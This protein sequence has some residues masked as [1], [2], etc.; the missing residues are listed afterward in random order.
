MS[1]L[2]GQTVGNYRILSMLGEG[3]MGVVYRALDTRLDREVA[4]KV[5]PAEMA[6][7]PG[8][9]KR[10]ETE[11]KAVA[12]LNHPSIVTIYSVEEVEGLRFLTME[13]V[14]GKGLDELIPEAGQP[15]ETFLGL[16][17]PI[18]DAVSAAHAKGIVH[19]DLKPGNLMVTE[20]GL[21]KVLD[22]GLAKLLPEGD[23]DDEAATV[24]ESRRTAVGTILGTVTYMS[25][26]QAEGKPVGPASDVFSLGT[27][28][29]EML[30][31][32]KPFEGDSRVSVLSAI[33]H[34]AQRPIR[35][36][37]RDL[38]KDVER[39]VA[40]CLEKGPEA[41]FPSAT[42]LC[43]DLEQCRERIAATQ[44]S[45]VAALRR[46]R[47]AVPAV[48]ALAIVLGAA[49]WFWARS[50][51]ARWA[52]SQ[53]LPEIARLVGE[54]NH[55]DAYVLARQAER[56]IPDDPQ[57]RRFQETITVPASVHTDPA[58]AEVWVKDYLAM[59]SDW[60]H[61]GS[62]PLDRFRM[63]AAFLR[64]R[65]DKEG[66]EAA[67]RAFNPWFGYG[68]FHLAVEQESPQGEVLVPAGVVPSGTDAVEVGQFWIDRY[69][70]TNR[71]F[72]EFV[73]AGGYREQEYW[74]EP[75]V[76]QGREL[77]WEEAMSEL[78]DRTGRPGPATWELG[79]YPEGEADYPV[80]G[81]CWYEAAA[82]AEFAGRSLP[83]V[84]HWRHAAAFD[85]FGEI[86][87][88]SNLEGDTPE[89]VG[90][91]AGVN[92]HGAHDM[93]GNVREW[94]WNS[95][96]DFRYV[97]GGA[98]NEPRYM[99]YDPNALPPFDRSE[100]NGLR[101]ARYSSPPAVAL[102]DDVQG[103]VYDFN[104]IEPVSDE[105]F[106]V[107]RGLYDY[108][109][110]P[111][112]AAIDA[113]DDSPKHWRR[114]TVGFTAAYGNERVIA[115][116]YLPR[117]AVPPY[118]AVVYFPGST[119][120]LQHS[121]ENLAE[122]SLFDLIPRSGRALVYPIYKGTYERG[123][124]SPLP[125]GTIAERDLLIQCA[126]DLRRT[127]DYLETRDDIDAD[128]LAFMGTS[129]GAVFGPVPVCI[130]ERFKAAVFLAGGLWTA[131][132]PLQPEVQ[133]W[134]YLPRVTMPVIMVNAR[135]DFAFPLET[136]QL[137]MFRLL[138]TPESDKH[139]AIL[140]GGHL[141]ADWNQAVREILDWLDRYLGPVEDKNAMGP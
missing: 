84:H 78:R 38:P 122:A 43:H 75:F 79:S 9:L 96:A 97:L 64:V 55:V 80:R 39:V 90:E 35:E 111:L 124:G 114:E 21:V 12:A 77:S 108:D 139:H 20:D 88:L 119:A 27:V 62:S 115:H 95:T 82:Y 138:G 37:R 107:Y 46:P 58:G 54:K 91:R 74:K 4:I 10:F 44:A 29:Y 104:E 129:W 86:L 76:H 13:V 116:L 63:P 132:L 112:D 89:P 30:T 15:L 140:E 68:E 93:A 94:C 26:E 17:V 113:V 36:L 1:E 141:P 19:R 92:L 49:G 41:R 123:P 65:L 16:A 72:Q 98:W 47:V 33:L 83:T 56:H 24:S 103:L 118:Q 18:A 133:P 70:V 121:S 52:R 14:E 71:Q 11:A 5:L 60:I 22:F 131:N 128:R 53:A 50:S 136:S 51:G 105:I 135:N 59:D 127:I 137:P 109:P 120:R 8:R 31:G 100:E 7:D 125:P 85:V 102:L 45:L 25:P 61:L 28:F 87:V 69:E 2:V 99:Y 34:Q 42:E 73:D 81:V 48:V 106:D 110:A 66:F 126:K 32:G 6:A 40:R 101:T 117:N 134:H 23:L 130:E 67:E 3:G 57:L